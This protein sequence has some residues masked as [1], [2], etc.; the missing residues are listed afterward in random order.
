MIDIIFRQI[1]YFFSGFYIPY[2]IRKKVENILTI[3]LG[4]DLE[5][6]ALLRPSLEA[7][8]KKSGIE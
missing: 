6:Y 4:P 8:F 5:V 3:S 1:G 7:V 2:A